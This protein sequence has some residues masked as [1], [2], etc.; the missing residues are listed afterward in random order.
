MDHLNVSIEN[1]WRLLLEDEFQKT[2]FTP[3]SISGKSINPKYEGVVCSGIKI[4]LTDKVKAR[5][6]DFAINF[7]QSVKK[8]HEDQFNFLSGNFI[9]KLYGS[10]K[11]RLSIENNQDVSLLIESWDNMKNKDKYFIY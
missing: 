2:Y 7:L 6:L 5:P 9:D 4:K 11:L 3:R 1:S 8:I 10:D